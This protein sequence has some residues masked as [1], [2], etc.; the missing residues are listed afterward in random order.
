MERHFPLALP[1]NS[2][3]V[4]EPSFDHRAIPNLK[5]KQKCKVGGVQVDII[6]KRFV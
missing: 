5:P 1:L 4:P 2:N 6:P 3:S